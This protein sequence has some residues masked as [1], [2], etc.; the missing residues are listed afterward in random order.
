LKTSE[1][2]QPSDRKAIMSFV[3]PFETLKGEK[4]NI[5]EAVAEW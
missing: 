4:F 3:E 1:R 5:V 2:G